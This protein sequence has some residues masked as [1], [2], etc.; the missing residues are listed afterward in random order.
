MSGETPQQ[1]V[2][3]LGAGP[4]GLTASYL[5]S[6]R[7]VP[8]T[9]LEADPQYVGGI[10]RTVQYK[11]YCFDIGGHRFY[12]KSKDVEDLWTEILP[13]D[14]IERSRSS[15]IFYRGK[16]FSYPLKPFEAFFKLGMIESVLCVLSFARA[17]FF[18]V[19]N[20]TN[21]QDWV[22][23]QFGKRLFGIFFKTY[24]EKVWGMKCSDISADWAAQRIKGLS[25][26]GAVFNPVK[27]AIGRVFSF[28]QSSDRK[29]E[30]KT[31]IETFRY[32]RKGPGMMWEACAQR[33][34]QQG[35]AV[36]MGCRVTALQYHADKKSWDVTYTE[37]G[38]QK[39]MNTPHVIS[40]L[41]I[42]ELVKSIKPGLKTLAHAEQLSY[43][44]FIIVAIVVKDRQL[45]DDN[46]IYIHSPIVKVGRVQNFKSW[47]P[48]MV[49]DPANNCFGMEYFCFDGDELWTSSDA[50]LIQLAKKELATLGLALEEDMFDASVIRQKKA[51]PVYDATYTQHVEAIREELK[52]YS[53]L[54]LIGRNGMHKYNNQDHSMMT[55]ML[56][57]E[58][59]IAGRE[60]YNVWLV[61]EDAEY[62]ESGVAGASSG[63]RH[64]PVANDDKQHD[65]RHQQQA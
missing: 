15:R 39:T 52:Q 48:D 32:P 55:A 27:K 5:L 7:G 65:D 22:S 6:K 29:K 14:I 41:P 24:T 33:T 10:S 17:K 46:W 45:F 38:A 47:S 53:G 64:V 35:G 8:C 28:A 51:Y 36:K 2:V 23:N 19:P 16:F 49:P 31:L 11:G 12:S 59:I 60:I 37:N 20:P 25:L 43:R 3:I 13:N 9:V 44:D 42:R 40:S 4:A 18:P 58:N 63:L 30:V 26:W 57:V 61:N 54:H 1:N 56:T 50:D 21:L 34:V 62:Q